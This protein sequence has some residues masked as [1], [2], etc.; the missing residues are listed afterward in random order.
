MTKCI[1]F[2]VFQSDQ[3]ITVYDISFF[4]GY[5]GVTCYLAQKELFYHE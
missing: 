3:G 4:H 1:C 2:S 5:L